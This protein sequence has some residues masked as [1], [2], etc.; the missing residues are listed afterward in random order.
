MDDFT[1]GGDVIDSP[2]H[3]SSVPVAWRVHMGQKGS[4]YTK[5]PRERL[6]YQFML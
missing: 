3:M 6:G 5:Q 1:P 2:Y 4:L